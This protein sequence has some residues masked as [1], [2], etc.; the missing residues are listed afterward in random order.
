M[1]PSGGLGARGYLAL[2]RPDSIE[3]G[4]IAACMEALALTNKYDHEN[5]LAECWP[6]RLRE[7]AGKPCKRVGR[8]LSGRR[9]SRGL[10]TLE[11]PPMPHEPSARVRLQADEGMPPPNVSVH[12][13]RARVAVNVPSRVAEGL[14][15]ATG[16]GAVGVMVRL[17]VREAM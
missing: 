9:L 3:Q 1:I 6:T 7:R 16:R 15:S 11:P 17:A 5:A 8:P 13:S 2:V 12:S 4:A 10:A 14:V